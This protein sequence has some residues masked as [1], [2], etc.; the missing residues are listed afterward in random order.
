MKRALLPSALAVAVALLVLLLYYGSY[1]WGWDWTGIAPSFSP[2]KKGR[3]YVAGKTLWDWLQLL[4]IPVVLAGVGIWFNARQKQYELKIA[5]DNRDADQRTAEANRAADLQ[6]SQGRQEEQVLA[7]YLDR[8]LDLLAK[9]QESEELSNSVGLGIT[10]SARA[11]TVT[12]IRQLN[13][14][15]NATLLRFLTESE[16]LK[17]H[18]APID[19]AK[20]NLE[21]ARLERVNLAGAN[22]KGAILRGADLE[23]AHV[24]GEQ[25]KT[26]SSLEDATMPSGLIF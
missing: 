1:R 23:G 14:E 11:R 12:A 2:P 20:A 22:L 3:D 21:V 25:V 10:M 7:T 17:R 6:I 15:R 16:L 18:N 13:S 4:I 19:L 8:M 26:V 24:R 5:Q 9:R